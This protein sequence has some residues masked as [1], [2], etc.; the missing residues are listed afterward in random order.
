VTP[1]VLYVGPFALRT[2]YAQAAHDYMLALHRA[3]VSLE[4]QP[5]EPC[6]T[7]DLDER[8]HELFELTR[9]HPDHQWRKRPTHV[10]V[11]AVPAA[12][13]SLAEEFDLRKILADEDLKEF[14][15]FSLIAITTWETSHIERDL[16]E[17]ILEAYD[18]VVVP[19]SFCA[20]AFT[21]TAS[22]P[23][24]VVI[25]HCF[26][27]KHWPTAPPLGC[28]RCQV[29][30]LPN[31]PHEKPYRF[32][33]ILSWNERKNPIGLLKAYYAEF[34]SD[35]DVVLRLKV[36]N[37]GIEDIQAL[38]MTLGYDDTPAIEIN[39]RY[40]NHDEMVAFHHAN[41]CFVTAARGEGWNLP[42][43]EAAILG[44]HV[45]APTFGGHLAFCFG[46]YQGVGYTET[47]AIV[48]PEIVQ[49]LEGVRA[50]TQTAPSGITARQ[51]WAEPDL[52]DLQRAMRYA[53]NRR[54]QPQHHCRMMLEDKFSYATVG[55]QLAE[56]IDRTRR[57]T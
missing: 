19:S 38:Q 13:P 46:S 37:P 42:A 39:N 34:S 20:Q 5:T 57:T 51:Y 18:V 21:T 35:D 4:I 3:G 54:I 7:D 48:P 27:P 50:V 15:P 2:G 30:E 10:I 32:Y 26:E 25:P 44:R 47:P 29:N 53:Y 9:G 23:T 17:A 14:G 24:I 33:S 49:V 45:I 22:S 41:D 28:E 52:G 6:H 8:Y 55:K 43:F 36:S 12:L 40:L 11:H 16:V 31:C 1:H 56:L